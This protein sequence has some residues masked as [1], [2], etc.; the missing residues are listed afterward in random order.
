[1]KRNRKYL[2][3]WKE[4]VAVLKV[5]IDFMQ[6]NS[7]LPSVLAIQLPANFIQFVKIFDFINVDFL[8][9][10]GATCAGATFMVRF[11]AMSALPMIAIL[12]G[13]FQYLHPQKKKLEDVAQEMFLVV[14]KDHSG[15]IESD[16]YNDLVKNFGGIPTTK[17][18]NKTEF[19][20]QLKTLD[21]KKLMKWWNNQSK[22]SHALNTTVQ[23][24]LLVHTPVTRMVFQYF[25]CH[26][27]HSKAFLKADYSIECWI[28]SY[29]SFLVYVIFIG[30]LFT[31][32][33]PLS[34]YLYITKHRR[35][36]YTP[37]IQA[38]IG[39]LYGSFV[40]RAE[41]WEV[42][43]IV[44]KTMLTGVIIYLQA[45]PTMQSSVAIMVCMIAIATLNYYEPHKNRIVFWLAQMSFVITGLKFL[46]TVILMA[47]N[48]NEVESIGILLI[49]L[50]LLFLLGSIIGSGIAIYLLWSK[51]KEIDSTKVVPNSVETLK[52]LRI[53]YG[54]NSVEY[55]NAITK[56]NK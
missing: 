21:Q 35:E 16:E 11:A 50:D 14:D 40:K 2:V 25:N 36:L 45:R 9:M 24:L 10:T 38:R 52:A 55:K 51:I 23:I 19:V 54:A 42:H 53:K 13:L 32:G 5:N 20:E 27:I 28:G 6:I 47:A 1:M 43:E 29:N 30:G 46:S 56:L 18:F 15:T 39:F 12:I 22:F 41:F 49:C 8:S 44:R 31:I 4:I 37:K 34:V 48:E 33:F 7:A 17:T 26:P 3:A